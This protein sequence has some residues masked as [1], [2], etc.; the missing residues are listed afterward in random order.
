MRMTEDQL[1]IAMEL[2]AKSSPV[3]KKKGAPREEYNNYD[4]NL[5]LKGAMAKVYK[6]LEGKSGWTS[7][8]ELSHGSGVSVATSKRACNALEG[9]GELSSRLD[10]RKRLVILNVNK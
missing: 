6:F 1:R 9:A 7:I 4:S 10:G 2:D 8:K 3:L 5:P